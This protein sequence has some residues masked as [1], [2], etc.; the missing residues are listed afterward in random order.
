MGIRHWFMDRSMSNIGKSERQSMMN[1][2]MEKFFAGM[3]KDEK[4]NMMN[5]MME[6]FSANITQD[7]KRETMRTMMPKMMSQMFGGEDGAP[8]RV[9]QMMTSTINEKEKGENEP[10][11]E[12]QTAF[13]PWECCP[14]SKLC[15]QAF[16]ETASSL[17]N[18]NA[19]NSSSHNHQIRDQNTTSR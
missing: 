7:E 2:M 17:D 13:R 5:G 18:P 9:M 16:K 14:C 19:N 3:T 1:E 12:A 15:E 11:I 6:K 4:Q 8:S 10:S